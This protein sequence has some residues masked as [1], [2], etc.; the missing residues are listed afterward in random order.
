LNR[1]ALRPIAHLED[2][3]DQK[4]RFQELLGEVR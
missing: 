4:A 1:R 3:A 2:I